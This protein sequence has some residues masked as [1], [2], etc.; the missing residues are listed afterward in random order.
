MKN[1]LL[2]TMI[3]AIVSCSKEKRIE[4]KIQRNACKD[5]SNQNVM[6]GKVVDGHSLIVSVPNIITPNGD[7]INDEFDIIIGS[8]NPH[9]WKNPE[10]LIL[11]KK[12]TV[13]ITLGDEWGNY[14]SAAIK[15]GVFD[16]QFKSTVDDI[17]HIL[18]GQLSIIQEPTELKHCETCFTL[19]ENDPLIK[20]K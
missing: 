18:T 19:D 14:G 8:A 15:E 7:G 16:Y 6:L 12:D 2:L 20:Y 10:L 11:D 9:D 4:N 17:E 3:L 1:L 5:T 13:Y